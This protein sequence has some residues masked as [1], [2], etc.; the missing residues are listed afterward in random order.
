MRKI[1]FCRQLDV[2]DCGAA[3]LKMILSFYG[4]ETSL[5]TI[6]DIIYVGNC[7]VSLLNIAK[8]AESLGLKT[9]SL[10]LTLRY[11]KQH[12]PFPC[13][14]HINNG[15]FVVLYKIKRTLR[16]K[17]K[18]YIADPAY[19]KIV[20]DENEFINIWAQNGYGI[21]LLMTPGSSWERASVTVNKT[22]NK[23]KEV[24]LSYFF[25][26]RKFFVPILLGLLITTIIGIC[27]PFFM[28]LI[29]DHGI[30]KKDVSFILN[31]LI[32]QIIILTSQMV[33]NYARNLMLVHINMRIGTH[34]ISDFLSKLM[35]IP[36]RFFDAKSQGDIMQRIHDHSCIEDF[37]TEKMLS[38]L[39]SIFNIIV[40]SIILCYYNINYFIIFIIGSIIS[41][42]WITLFNHKR[43][44]IN[45]I[46]FQ[47]NREYQDSI[48][49]I[50]HGM[51]EIK[52][53]NNDLERRWDWEHTQAKLFRLNLKN[54][55]LEQIQNSGEFL[56]DQLKNTIIIFFAANSVINGNITIGMLMSIS[57]IMGALNAPFNQIV[58][59]VQSWQDAHL[60]LS[61]LIELHQIDDE[62]S[63][64]KKHIID[65]EISIELNNV[66]FSYNGMSDS[67]LLSDINIRVKNGERV[68]LVG[69]SGC[70]KTT[71]MKLLLGYY[72]SNK[73]EILING[74]N[75][76]NISLQEW[77][78][79]VGCVLQDGYIFSDT[80][81]NNITM[82]KQFDETLFQLAINIS[83]SRSFIDS[84]P[85]KE[86]TR[87]GKSGMNLSVGQK[88]RILIARAIYKNP[89]VLFFDEATSALDSL[90]EFQI[91]QKLD[92]FMK[93]RTSV[94]IAHRLSTVKSADR[95]YV[96]KSGKIIEEGTHEQL[97]SNKGYY[98]NLIEKQLM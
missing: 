80:I 41:I 13:I 45:Y 50:L 63:Y 31:I 7:G 96:L 71:I 49:E 16:G 43:K 35:R 87:I 66:Y 79:K 26:S 44:Q 14:I 92:S 30:N 25:S 75:I 93:N 90:N 89:Q 12:R 42:I 60:S 86:L 1:K 38:A 78:D 28:Q 88:Q 40:F 15:H 23:A 69:E 76:D 62:S 39:F 56:I 97:I 22:S 72:K 55:K 58:L 81:K 32:A 91:S 19:G 98:Y 4:H 52:L 24:F 67:Y 5:M 54:L 74:E 2:A 83:N 85:L 77:R 3:C 70:G 46:R 17:Y 11:L 9:I 53:N 73:G 48:Y 21:V 29:V 20:I 36:I 37:L 8:G 65:E 34:I 61:R 68:A 84:L 10:R 57:F 6:K 33:V 95:I 82:R 47:R 51:P 64:R 94:I 59:L 18:Y 27:L